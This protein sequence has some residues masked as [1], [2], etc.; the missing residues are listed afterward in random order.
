MF[1]ALRDVYPDLIKG[2]DL[3]NQ[4]E[5]GEPL[6]KFAQQLWAVGN[7]TNFFFHAG[8]TNW[9]GFST[10]ENLIDAVLLRSKRI[11]HG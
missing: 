7:E 8:E 1:K 11:G 5:L 6:R 9:Y 2:F 3:V 4:E 10:D